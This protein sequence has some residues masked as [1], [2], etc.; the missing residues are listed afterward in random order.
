MSLLSYIDLPS[1]LPCLEGCHALHLDLESIFTIWEVHTVHNW[2][3]CQSY[4]MQ[5]T[6][7]FEQKEMIS[8]FLF[9]KREGLVF[10]HIL[11]LFYPR[12]EEN[13]CFS[14]LFLFLSQSPSLVFPSFLH[15]TAVSLSFLSSIRQGNQVIYFYLIYL[16]TFL[17]SC[18]FTTQLKKGE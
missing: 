1:P 17:L 11:H 14:P 16:S 9:H 2:I 15:A 5:C 4:F 18:H 7:R 8:N 3:L 12:F 13:I 10:C 6:N